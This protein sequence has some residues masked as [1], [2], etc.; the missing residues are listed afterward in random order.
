MGEFMHPLNEQEAVCFCFF[1]KGLT[2]YLAVD[3]LKLKVTANLNRL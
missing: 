2:I 1:L 3:L